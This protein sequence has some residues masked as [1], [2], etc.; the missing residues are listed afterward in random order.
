MRYAG[1]FLKWVFLSVLVGAVGG[2]LGSVFHIAIDQVTEIRMEHG[3][4]IL[5]LPL[6]CLAIMGMYHLFASQG[7]IDTNR[8]IES[9]REN[10]KV[11]IVMV[12]LI[13][14]ATVIVLSFLHMR[15]SSFEISEPDSESTNV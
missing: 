1:V 4:I 7:K 11:P 15:R 10:G 2:A 13:F 8:V 5:L 3:F 6:G 14:L 12:P 9:V